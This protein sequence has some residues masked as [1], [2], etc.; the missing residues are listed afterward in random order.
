M[1]PDA[2]AEAGVCDNGD[3]D[4]DTE[5]AVSLDDVECVRAK[6]HLRDLWDKH[7]EMKR[8]ILG[9]AAEVF[10]LAIGLEN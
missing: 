5:G 6:C 9:T 7:C 2:V 1:S 3:D 8:K 10:E 4:R